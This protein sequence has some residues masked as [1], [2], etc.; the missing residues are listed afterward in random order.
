MPQNFIVEKVLSNI[1]CESN[2][3][4]I[5]VLDLSC[6]EGEILT[7]L[8]NLGCEVRGTRFCSNDYIIE[9]DLIKNHNESKIPIDNEIDLTKPLPY[10]DK[11]FNVVILTEVIEHIPEYR[12]I[13]YESS[14]ILKP[15]G[16]LILT[17]PN[18]YRLHSRFQFFLF[19]NH[20]VINRRLGWDLGKED[21]Y[22][23]HISPVDFL[24]L[25]VLMYQVNL[26]IESF[27]FTRFKWRHAGWLM[28]YPLFKMLAYI[29]YRKGNINSLR[30]KGDDDLRKYM[31]SFP[32]MF[33][34]QLFI[35]ARKDQF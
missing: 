20:K 17:T 21:L 14:R 27:V 12:S 11:S 15:N 6:G 2:F 3:P 26:K 5:S 33:S 16:L 8:S 28:V 13:I 31:T 18:I 10:K 1:K 29:Y 7:K 25:H 23:Y 4:N 35:S 34:E 19:G 32:I 9:N 22:A 30:R 24:Y